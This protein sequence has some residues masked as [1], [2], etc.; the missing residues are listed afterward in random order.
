[1]SMFSRNNTVT[2]KVP[3]RVKALKGRTEITLAEPGDRLTVIHETMG[4]DVPYLVRNTNPERPPMFRVS[5]TELC[6][7]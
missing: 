3:L 2:V 5:A 1:M 4:H 6:H 7:L